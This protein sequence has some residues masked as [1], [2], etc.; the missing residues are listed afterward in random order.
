MIQAEPEGQ[1]RISTLYDRLGPLGFG[2][3]ALGNLFSEV[4]HEQAEAAIMSAL[5]N[6]IR[7]FDTAPYYGYGLSEDR[8]GQM[9]PANAAIS[10]KVGRL[11]ER[12][13]NSRNDGFA[14]NGNAWFD[15]SRDGILRSFENSLSRLRRDRVTLLL[16]HDVGAL[17]HGANHHAMLAEAL[18]VALPAMAELKRQGLCDA[19]GIGVNEVAV[20][21]EIMARMPLDAILLAG[22]F[23]LIEPMS[24]VALLDRAKA[25]GTAMIIGGA[26]NSGL[27]AGADRPGHFYDYE[28]PPASVEA[29]AR[30]IYAIAARHDVDV[31]AAALAYAGSHPAIATTLVG[32]RDAGEVIVTSRRLANAIPAEFWA[33]LVESGILPAE[34]PH[35]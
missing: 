20:C 5:A 18:D 7:Y 30:A 34:A 13:G 25:S 19:I 14:V 3:A 2:G 1:F 29:R 9:L 28:A 31:G 12:G 35:P 4:S 23:T 17:T 33:D 26:Y 11:V 32:M 27:L 15:Y 24:A 6:G 22:R 21:T 8:L 16:L 10:T